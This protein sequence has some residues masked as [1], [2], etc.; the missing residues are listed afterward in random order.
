MKNG[1]LL[2]TF[3]AIALGASSASALPITLVNP[4]TSATAGQACQASAYYESS[5]AGIVQIQLLDA[6]WKQV[7]NAWR[8][9]AAGSGTE[10][11]TLTIPS[12]TTPGTGYRWQ[13]LLYNSS[14]SKNGE[15]TVNSVTILPAPDSITL[16]APLTVNA[17]SNIPVS[18]TYQQ[19][20]G[21]IVQ[22]QLMDPSW[23]H[24]VDVWKTVSATSG[25]ETLSLTV[26][27]STPTGSGYRWQAL[28]YDA[29]WKKK[30]DLT[31]SNVAVQAQGTE[32]LPSG[33]WSLEWSDEFN[34]AAGSATDSKVTK[35]YPMLG[36]TPTDFTNNAE[37]GLRWSGS[38]EDTARFYSTKVGNHWLDGQGNLLIRAVA[39]KVAPA[40]ANGTR[41]KSAYLMS[42]YPGS[43]D[44]S[45]PTGVK[46][47]AGNGKFVS[48]KVGGVAKDCYISARVR[49]DQV[50][51]YSTWFAFWL[52]TETRPYDA[53]PSNGTEVD[54]IEIAKG[55]P[56]YL[57]KSFNVANH[58]NSSGGSES[59]QFSAGTTPSSTSFVDVTDSNY[60]TYGIEWSQSSMKCTVDGKLYYTFTGNIPTDPVDMMMLLTLEFQPNAWDP[61][62]GDGRTAGPYV[63]DSSSMREMSRALID[64]VR[65]YRK[66]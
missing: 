34:G 9:V 37:K 47:V 32:W 18:V 62:Q 66:N 45:E 55:A 59:H 38:T 63:S 53:V 56:T 42:G 60:H 39:D 30:T 12:T 58:W 4:P 16:D 57:L 43:W 14:W 1:Q 29:A 51:G 49:T 44:S 23:N 19:T 48:P 15:A 52:F 2:V 26:P 7:A 64:Y 13:A 24:V 28:L 27:A 11:F 21:G 3:L 54:L 41:V 6:S 40:N 10:S 50:Q 35:W 22:V 8:N 46:W 17:G 25:T 33:T 36:Y 61:N 31:V 65:V 5:V 20:T